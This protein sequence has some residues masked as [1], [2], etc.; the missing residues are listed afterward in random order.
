MVLVV[1]MLLVIF[2]IGVVLCLWHGRVS[3]VIFVGEWLLI[4]EVDCLHLC[5]EERL[6][7]EHSLRR[8]EW[9]EVSVQLQTTPV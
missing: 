1:V 8:Q 4:I 6:D 5:R 7:I 2:L 3:V 9:F